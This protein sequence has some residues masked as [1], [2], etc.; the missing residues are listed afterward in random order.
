[1]HKA[2]VDSCE[3]LECYCKAAV[4]I[5]RKAPVFLQT[6]QNTVLITQANLWKIQVMSVKCWQKILFIAIKLVSHFVLKRTEHF[7]FRDVYSL[8]QLLNNN[9]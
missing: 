6:E 1:M 4:F 9:Q 5:Y 2:I 3:E 8:K 7:W